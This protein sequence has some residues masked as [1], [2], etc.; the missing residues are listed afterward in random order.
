MATPGERWGLGGPAGGVQ[1]I[2]GCGNLHLNLRNGQEQAGE[3]Y[4]KP[5]S[6]KPSASQ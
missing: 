4:P 2:N 1:N 6:S 3:A 5:M